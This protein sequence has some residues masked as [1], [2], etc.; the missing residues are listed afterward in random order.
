MTAPGD[1]SDVEYVFE[2]HSSTM[3]DLREYFDALWDRR[4]FMV[5][6]AKTDLRSLRSSTALGSIWAI[7]DPLFQAGIYYFLYVVLRGA[8]SSQVKFLPVLIAG[9]YLFAISMA[10]L[11]DG[12]T[13]IRRAKGLMLN[14]TFPRALLPV[15]AV[16][17][18]IRKFVPSACVLAVVFPLVGGQVGIGLFVFPLLFALQ[19]VMCIGTALLVSTFVVLFPDGSNVMAYVTRVLFFATPV[20]YPVTLLPASARLIVGWQPL[21]ALFASYQAVFSGDVPNAGLVVQTAVWAFALLFI[22][23]QVFLRHERQF[24]IRL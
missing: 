12:G 23:S 8:Q 15:T 5:A 20:V 6:L 21:F 3:P 2:P 10:A 14:S 22:G 11:G 4:H 7:L 19:V 1:Y 9:F 16:Y 13:S 17:K 18:S 24:T